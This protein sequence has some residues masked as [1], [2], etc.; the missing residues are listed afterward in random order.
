MSAVVDPIAHIG[1]SA[2]QS[3][4]ELRQL[5]VFL[6][7]VELGSLSAAAQTLG[8][9]QST[10]S[11]A[12][13]ALDRAVGTPTVRRKRGAHATPLTPAGEAL[14]PHARRLLQ[15]VDAMH[16]AIAEVSRGAQA[17]LHVIAN[18]SVS[19][20]LLSPAL[21]TL[22]KRWPKVRVSVTVGT[23]TDIRAALASGRGDVGLLLDE[24]PEKGAR[25]THVV[26]D[27]SGVAPVVLSAGIP[28]VVFGGPAHPL[29]RRGGSVRRDML[30][31]FSLLIADSAGDFHQLVRRYFSA[32]GLPGPSLESVGSIEAVKR[33]VEADPTA[34]GLLP[35]YALA[36][37]LAHGR[38]HALALQPPPPR[39]QLIALTTESAISGHPLID[40]LLATMRSA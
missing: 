35:Q 32:E 30:Q 26:G 40:E 18:E 33:G 37:D 16:L 28:L 38:V 6:A 7:V 13:S 24:Q 25:A 22:R 39:M 20:Y 11:E 21:G 27:A 14:L 34:L 8:L 36:E 23:C 12:L 10:V 29:V 9:A 31:P 19:T 17:N 2:W 5:R 4:V 3:A 15:E 1:T